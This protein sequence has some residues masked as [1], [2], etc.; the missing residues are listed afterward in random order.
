MRVLFLWEL[1]TS[2]DLSG[3][4]MN[5]NM[6]AVLEGL[7]RTEPHFCEW[8]VPREKGE[9]SWD[10]AYFAKPYIRTQPVGPTTILPYDHPSLE[11]DMFPALSPKKGR[12]LFDYVL[13]Q[14]YLHGA[15][16]KLA[17]TVPPGKWYQQIEVPVINYVTETSLDERL[18]MMREEAGQ[19]LLASSMA[20][21]PTFVMNEYDRDEV[22][23]IAR[24]YLAPSLVDRVLAQIHVIRACV[25]HPAID[26]RRPEMEV[27]RSERRQL[28]GKVVVFH[29][30]SLENKRHL[31]NGAKLVQVLTEKGFPVRG[32]FLTQH[33]PTKNPFAEQGVELRI[34]IK[35][36]P[37]LDALHE[38]DVLFC[39]A[40]Y[41]GTGL[42]YMEAIRA[43]QIPVVTNETWIKT[44]LPKDYPFIA[45]N[46]DDFEVKLAYVVRNF[47]EVRD[48]WQQKLIA[49]LDPW[50]MVDVA[51][52]YA[53]AVE[54]VM[55][56]VR[57]RNLELVQRISP[58]FGLLKQSVE[59]EK[60]ERIEELDV[61]YKAM[62]NRSRADMDFKWVS[63]LA[64]RW[65]LMALGYKDL[66][67]APTP[68]MVRG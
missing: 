2:K 64:I 32:L 20:V 19:A 62:Q 49:H 4:S 42:A 59:E 15:A 9:L 61:V 37:Y 38:G 67:D 46:W 24:R 54:K 33:T 36:G 53:E 45:K 27:K 57:E 10:D 31:G 14:R 7:N 39:A 63:P 16:L 3:I 60:W 47:E 30:G 18:P 11:P 40:D 6:H 8:I 58:A 41:E 50:G 21:C 29:G 5:N 28:E 44:R 26:A 48:A 25:E 17:F 34:G 1:Y 51:R 52:A 35:H 12:V 23:R 65:M 56:P 68:R 22:L 13:N 43:G 66:C 55:V